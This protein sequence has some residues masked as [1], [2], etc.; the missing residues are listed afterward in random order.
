MV[1]YLQKPHDSQQSNEE[2][3]IKINS[4]LVQHYFFHCQGQWGTYP[5]DGYFY[6]NLVYHAIE[7]KADVLLVT[8]MADFN[9]MAAKLRVFKTLFNLQLDLLDFIH[10]L[11]KQS[12]V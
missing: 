8:L 11:K 6:Q 4:T 7:A 9:W 1:D 2:Y 12:K 3:W 10:Y 5:N